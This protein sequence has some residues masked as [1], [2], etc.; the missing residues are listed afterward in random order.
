MKTNENTGEEKYYDHLSQREQE[1]LALLAQNLSDRE[2]AARLFLAYATVK[3]YNRQIYNKLGVDNRQNAVE[4]ATLLGLLKSTTI[5][6]RPKHNLPAQLTP[7][8]GR[9]GELEQ[10]GQF[11]H[12]TSTRL[13]TLLAPGGMGKTRLALEVAAEAAPKFSDGVYFIPLAPLTLAEQL[14]TAVASSIGLQFLQEERSPKQ[15]ILDFLRHKQVLLL[16]DNYEHLLDGTSLVD[17]ILRNASQVKILV[18]SRERL[19]LNGETVFAIDGLLYP[20]QSGEEYN[21]EYPA[22]QLF[23]QCALRAYPQFVLHDEKSMLQI[24]QLV[25]G[26]PLAI[27]LASAWVGTLSLSEITVEIE[28]NI[29]FLSTSMA[30]IPPRL[31]SIRA[32]FDA[33]WSR[34]TDEERHVFSRMSVFHA[35]CTR[36]AAQHIA[37]A[38]AHIL[39]GLVNKA[40]LWHQLEEQ[41]YEIHELMRQYAAEQLAIA[42]ETEATLKQHLDYFGEYARRWATALKTPAQLEALDRLDADFENL[43]EAFERAIQTAQASTVEPFTALWY[44]FEIRGRYMEGMKL[45]ESAIE[46]LRHTESIAL[47]KLLAGYGL[48]LERYYLYE[49]ALPYAEQSVS[50]LRHLGAVTEITMPMMVLG[51]A[52][53]YVYGVQNA[54]TTYEIGLAIAER[55][56]DDWAI[57]C[58]L[59]LLGTAALDMNESEE[60]KKLI[61]QAY[62]LMK[63]ISNFW[64]VG[65]GLVWLGSIALNAQDYEEA[66][67]L[68][69][70]GVSNARKIH[71]SVIIIGGLEGLRDIA[72]V[73]N[74][75]LLAQHLTEE[76][77]KIQRDSGNETGVFEC[78]VNLANI[79]LLAGHIDQAKY[80]VR[81]ALGRIRAVETKFMM[82]LLTVAADLCQQCGRIE[83]SIEIL[84]FIENHPTRSILS[85]TKKWKSLLLN[86]QSQL[87]D[88][89]YRASYERGKTYTLDALLA[90]LSIKI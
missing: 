81:Q 73:K 15:Q 4:R 50:I 71:H 36:E 1:V 16:L 5:S 25:Q 43:R 12:Q 62:M 6:D 47:A 14:I 52:Q 60:G 56:D 22:I 9:M 24:C 29:D 3:W 33:T 37:G 49:K 42:G 82:F 45:F 59:F 64:A 21:L 69:E 18:T 27:E 66:Q 35:G 54:V 13:I 41:R 40:L 17:E 70:E 2:I 58:F 28:Q 90:L 87:L 75:F 83:F 53:R 39:A 51:D 77:L 38:N 34:L 65:F 88:E 23:L 61:Y 86:G 57:P 8:I 84:S 89:S 26:M 78:I 74:D 67:S 68:F 85:T 76:V 20:E 10:L 44:Y 31:R 19:N 79:M 55:N 11:I 7:F 80:Y 63:N 48:F 46:K 72:V 30:N 32:V